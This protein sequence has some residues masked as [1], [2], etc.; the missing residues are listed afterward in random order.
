LSD[1]LNL[2]VAC[3]NIGDANYRV[4]GSGISEPGRNFILAA[5]FNF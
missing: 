1:Q 5:E 3:E 2:T 4:H